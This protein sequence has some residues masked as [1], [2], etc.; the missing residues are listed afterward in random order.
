MA[1]LGR[2]RRGS[3]LCLHCVPVSPST[4]LTFLRFRDRMCSCFVTALHVLGQHPPGLGGDGR[5]RRRERE[6]GQAARGQEAG[7]RPFPPSQ[8]H[9]GCRRRMLCRAP[10]FCSSVAFPNS[11]QI[12]GPISI[13]GNV[14]IVL[15][16]RLVVE[17]APARAPGRDAV[18]GRNPCACLCLRHVLNVFRR[19]VG[20]SVCVLL[21]T[22]AGFRG[23]ASR[24]R[25][26]C[27]SPV[28]LRMG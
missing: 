1:T 11:L 26:A 10:G 13:E 8:S 18:H 16:I 19:D 4:A 9:G 12:K 23:F 15:K 3:H 7:S 2:S 22:P 25:A 14:F 27:P 20:L 21:A 6:R 5:M 24:M 17:C 28:S